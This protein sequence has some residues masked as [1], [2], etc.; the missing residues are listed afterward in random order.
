MASEQKDGGD[1][2]QAPQEGADGA[3]QHR[4]LKQRQDL[5]QIIPSVAVGLRQRAGLWV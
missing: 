4:V 2:Q 5:G 3:D 1:H